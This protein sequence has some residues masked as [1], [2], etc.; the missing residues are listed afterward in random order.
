MVTSTQ[1]R[2]G[3]LLV[4]L[5]SHTFLPAPLVSSLPPCVHLHCSRFLSQVWVPSYVSGLS[6][7]CRTPNGHSYS[8]LSGWTLS[9]SLG[10]RDL[11]IQSDTF[12]SREF[13]KCEKLSSF[14]MEKFH[15]RFWS[16]L[17]ERMS[18]FS[19]KPLDHTYW[20]HKFPSQRIRRMKPEKNRESSSVVFLRE[21]GQPMGFITVVARSLRIQSDRGYDSPSKA[22][23]KSFQLK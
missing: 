2:E 19:D 4:Y 16:T 18:W 22:F 8:T 10:F 7:S 15:H 11:K 6:G 5:P 14:L 3:Q 17:N 20:S 21:L 9:R 13:K 1:A 12:Y 23:F